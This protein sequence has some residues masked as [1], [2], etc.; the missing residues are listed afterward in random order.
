MA[1]L[2]DTNILVYRYD[3]RFPEKQQVATSVLRQ[4][5]VDDTLRISHQAIVEFVSAVTRPIE[6][7]RPLLT[8]AEAHREVEDLLG[9]FPVLYPTESVVRTAVRGA[10]TYQL[11]WFDAHVWAFAECFGL[12]T[13]LS[14]DFQ[15]GRWYG[16]VRV[17]NPFLGG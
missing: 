5:L 9:Q 8:S 1:A 12:D 16:T 11:S 13:L 6:R 15:H 4:G 10:A 14:E 7:G 2:V 3:P 17:V